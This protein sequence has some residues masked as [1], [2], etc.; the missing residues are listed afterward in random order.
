MDVSSKA[1]VSV[2]LLIVSSHVNCLDQIKIL[3]QESLK[4][5]WF[6]QT[7]SALTAELQWLKVA[8]SVHLFPHYSEI[9]DLVLCLLSTGSSASRDRGIACGKR[10]QR[11][12]CASTVLL[13]RSLIPDISV[14]SLQDRVS[15]LELDNADLTAH[16]VTT[17]SQLA[18]TQAQ[19][20]RREG[21]LAR[22][23]ERER[24]EF[25]EEVAV[26][27][28]KLAAYSDY[29]ELK[30]ELDI[31]KVRHLLYQGRH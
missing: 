10:K 11:N 21:E 20:S 1:G 30:R 4:P 5:I 6:L 18:T 23:E 25:I 27:R 7:W 19:L 3:S 29:D 24:D 9:I 16:L 17:Q 31:M 8:M 22:R 26:L 2:P 15:G 14:S 13:V 28:K 12:V